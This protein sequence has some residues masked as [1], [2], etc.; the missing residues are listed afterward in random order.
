MAVTSLAGCGT[1]AE[2][3]K[4]VLGTDDPTEA[5]KASRCFR[6]TMISFVH[7]PITYLIFSFIP[8]VSTFYNSFFEN[9]A[10]GLTDLYFRF[11]SHCY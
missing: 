3:A 5:Q 1:K 8:L 9:Y 2:T 10:V 11:S 7:F 6:N 4:T